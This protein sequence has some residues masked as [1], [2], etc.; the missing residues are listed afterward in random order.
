M[1]G[2]PDDGVLRIVRCQV[3]GSEDHALTK[4]HR[5][6]EKDTPLLREEKVRIADGKDVGKECKGSSRELPVAEQTD[7]GAVGGVLLTAGLSQRR[8]PFG[9]QVAADLAVVHDAGRGHQGHSASDGGGIA[10]ALLKEPDRVIHLFGAGLTCRREHAGRIEEI[11]LEDRDAPVIAHRE[12]DVLE[13]PAECGIGGIETVAVVPGSTCGDGS[14]RCVPQEPLAVVLIDAGVLVADK[15]RDPD[16]G[17]HTAAQD[18]LR[19]RVDAVREG[20]PL[21]SQPVSDGVLI[22]LV[23]AEDPAR[24]SRGRITDIL[25]IPHEL[26]LRDVRLVTVPGGV[27]GDRLG[28]GGRDAELFEVSVKDLVLRAFTEPYVH[29]GKSTVEE[30]FAQVFSDGE[31]PLVRV[32]VEKGEPLFFIKRAEEA[33]PGVLPDIA[34]A[35]AVEPAVL[36]RVVRKFTVARAVRLLMA[37]DLRHLLDGEVRGIDTVFFADGPGLVAVHEDVVFLV[38]TVRVG[39]DQFR[40]L[41]G[42][43]GCDSDA[44]AV[45]LILHF[46]G[47]KITRFPGQKIQRALHAV[48]L[49]S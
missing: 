30:A 44:E 47:Q 23:D 16:P 15:G 5:T 42:S 1:D 38:K 49:I 22:A 4:A 11:K 36:L 13:M 48:L 39:D 37:Y 14:A 43:C 9:G 21:R 45:L 18:L 33:E 41:D 10:H 12:Q 46:E 2:V 27:A 26:L 6:A 28:P 25:D 3:V 32:D 19:D 29:R 34:V 40:D 24:I 35:H 31:G 7:Q 8:E 17:Q 20:I